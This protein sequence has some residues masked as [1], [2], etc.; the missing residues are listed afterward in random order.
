MVALAP[1]VSNLD[2]DAEA[3]EHLRNHPDQVRSVLLYD[4]KQAL[5]GMPRLQSCLVDYSGLAS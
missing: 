1:W 4:F 3:G 5:V 2:V